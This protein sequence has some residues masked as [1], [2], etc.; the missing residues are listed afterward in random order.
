MKNE[1]SVE[2]ISKFIKS[3]L[4]KYIEL[5]IDDENF[6]MD[7]QKSKI[8]NEFKSSIINIIDFEKSL[9]RVKIKFSIIFYHRINIFEK[10]FYRNSFYI[11]RNI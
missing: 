10:Y 1:E 6:V 2:I 9:F 4:R 7:I 8:F 5:L 3:D 11:K